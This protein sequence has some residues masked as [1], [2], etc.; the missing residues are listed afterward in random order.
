MTR[1]TTVLFLI[2]SLAAGGAE[3]QLCELVKHMDRVSFDIHVAVFYGPGYFNGGE[4]WPEIA[5]LPDVTLHDLK[6]RRG[7]PGYFTALPKL[8]ALILRIRADV[9]HG[10]IDGNLPLLL[11]GRLLRRPIVWGIRSTDKD[12]SKLPPRSRFMSTFLLRLARFVDLVIFNS[13]SGRLSHLA[14]GM[15]PPRMLVV[16]NGFDITRFAP[17]PAKGVAQRKAWGIPEDVPLIGVVGRLNPVKDHPTFLRTVARV[18]ND[19][20]EARFVCVGGGPEAYLQSLKVLAQSMGI[21]DRLLWAGVSQ[22]MPSAYNALSV[23]VLSSADEGFPNA[24]GEA[25]ACGIPCVATRVGDAEFLI[26]D[27]GL[28]T[29]V[30]DDAALAEAISTLLRETPEARLLRATAARS[31]ICSTFSVESLARTTETA[32]LSLLPD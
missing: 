15:K 10:Y 26:G 16:P 28:T 31:R 12:Q 25:M 14:M 5:N 8:L 1:K 13:E 3:R 4:L 20:P 27:T 7:V 11:L 2:D 19:W 22:S 21:Q 18:S 29:E 32:L 30:A 9:L 6:K 17:D 23:L 24:L